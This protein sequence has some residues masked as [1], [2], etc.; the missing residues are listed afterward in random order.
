MN[1]SRIFL[2]ATVAAVAM[3]GGALAADYTLKLG[4]VLAPT[5]PLQVAAEGMKKAVEERSDGRLEIELYPSSQLGDTQDMMD[6]AA[7]GANVGTFVEASRVSVFVPEFDVLVAPYAFD[8]VEEIARFVETDTFASWND[9][10]REKSGLTLLSYN[11]YQGARH[12]L[13][14]K[15]VSEPAD[16][17]GVR[18]RTIGQPLWVETIQAMGAVPTPLAWAEVYPSIQTGAIDGAEAQPSAIWGSKLHEV[19]SDITLTGHIHLM[20]GL[21]VSDAWL[22]SLPEDLR[23]IITEEAKNWGASAL[24]NNVESADKIFADIRETGVNVTEIDTTPFKEAVQPVYEKLNLT[25]MVEE[26]RAA[27]GE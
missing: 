10:L 2:L 24:K 8:N 19:V 13:T 7:A 16:L 25:E 17:E 15:P 26:V 14:K 12:L 27:L 11:W 22:Q 23:T 3:P 21:L 18:V 6:Q 5:D 4:S 20:S 9:Q 1:I